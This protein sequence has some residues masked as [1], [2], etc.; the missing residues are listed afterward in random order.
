MTVPPW[1][2]CCVKDCL[3]PAVHERV[4]E[5]YNAYTGSNM[6]EVVCTLGYCA[7]HFVQALRFQLGRRRA[8]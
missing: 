4:M 2:R 5:E 7:P 6:V 8:A 3:Q 1:R